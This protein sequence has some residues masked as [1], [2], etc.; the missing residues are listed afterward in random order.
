LNLGDRTDTDAEADDRKPEELALETGGRVF[1]IPRIIKARFGEHASGP[2][3]LGILGRERTLLREGRAARKED[4][5][6]A[7]QTCHR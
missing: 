7:E 5:N 2:D 3:R 1:H 6:R 4:E